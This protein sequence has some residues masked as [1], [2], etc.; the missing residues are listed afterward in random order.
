MKPFL[1]WLALA[2]AFSAGAAETNSIVWHP[3]GRVDADIAHLALMPLLEQITAETGWKVYVEPG[4]DRVA[5]TKFSGEPTDEALRKLLGDLNFALVPQTNAAAQLYIFRTTRQNATRLVSAAQVRHVPNEVILRVKPGTDIAALAKLLGAK[6][7]GRIDKLGLYRLQFPDSASADAALAQL[8]T[9]SDVLAAGYNNYFD[10][11]PPV[12]ATTVKNAPLPPVSLKLN[13]PPD[14]GKIIV[15]LIDTAVQPLDGSLN[16]FLMKQVSVAEGTQ[17]GSDKLIHGTAMAET[18]LRALSLTEQGSSSVQILPVD[19]YGSSPSA[20]TW[21]VAKGIVDA[22]NSG[23][24]VINLSLGGAN[25]DPVLADVITSVVKDGIPIFAAAGNTPTAAATYPAAFPGVYAVTALE[26]G[27]I[28]PYANYGSFVDFAVAD[29][30]IAYLGKQA[31]FTAGTSVST[32]NA[33]GMAAGA[34]DATHQSWSQITA[35]L[36]LLFPVPSR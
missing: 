18:I 28:A 23:A 26:Q 36:A 17:A 34:A 19:V 6:I 14:S 4:T 2:A 27:K 11:P 16:S 32:A 21:N 15:G 35:R 12:E 8:Q 20:N 25:A 1:P 10:A 24:N 30:T 22:V 3:A 33:T 7:T 13:P 31:Y 9:D 29:G 5:S